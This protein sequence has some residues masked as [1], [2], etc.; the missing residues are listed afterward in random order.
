MFFHNSLKREMLFAKGCRRGAVECP[1]W[2]GAG[3]H[4]HSACPW[5]LLFWSLG[6]PYQS[7]TLKQTPHK[8][9]KEKEEGV[10]GNCHILSPHCLTPHLPAISSDQEAAGDLALQA[11]A[12][13]TPPLVPDSLPPPLHSSVVALQ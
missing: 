11:Q 12:R 2:V 7:L 5:V 3:A 10:P 4:C 1:G 6:W 9:L 8:R 13:P